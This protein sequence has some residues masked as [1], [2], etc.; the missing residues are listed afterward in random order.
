MSHPRGCPMPAEEPQSRATRPEDRLVAAFGSVHALAFWKSPEGQVMLASYGS[1]GTIRRWDFTTGA[2][3]D[4]PLSSH[5]WVNFLTAWTGQ[6]GKT[7]LASASDDG[8]R[9]WDAASGIE[10]P[11]IDHLDATPLYTWIRE[12]RHTM[13]A[14]G[15][16]DGTDR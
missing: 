2:E 4:P 7:M 15:G 1:D 9:R 16:R 11:L 3:T 12:H 6:D 5:G 8:I 13:L 14:S 10:K